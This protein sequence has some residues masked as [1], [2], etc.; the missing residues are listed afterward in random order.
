MHGKAQSGEGLEVRDIFQRTLP[1]PF[2]TLVI[3]TQ[4]EGD[5]R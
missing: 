1:L 5:H 3:Q 4:G 2:L